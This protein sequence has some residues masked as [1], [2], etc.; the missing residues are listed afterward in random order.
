MRDTLSLV[1]SNNVVF[2]LSPFLRWF[3][4][5]FLHPDVVA[6]YAYI[7]LWDEDIGVENF[8]VGR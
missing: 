3:A 1:V 5:R 7:F 6:E 4:K 8:R 2:T